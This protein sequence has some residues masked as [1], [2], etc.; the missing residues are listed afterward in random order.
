MFWYIL[1]IALLNIC[2]GFALAAHLGAR[3][4]AMLAM[5]G[6][7]QSPAPSAVEPAL[8]TTKA[9]VEPSAGEQAQGASLDSEFPSDLFGSLDSDPKVSTPA[10]DAPAPA[11]ESAAD[12][13]PGAAPEGEPSESPQPASR[14]E[15]TLEASLAEAAPSEQSK[16]DTEAL[17]AVESA[18]AALEGEVATYDVVLIETNEK[19]RAQVQSPE[20]AAIEACL[21]SLLGA[22]DQYI[23][24]RKQ[25]QGQL[26]E[27]QQAASTS[28]PDAEGWPAAVED[29]DRGIAETTEVAQSFDSEGDLSEQCR[30]M[31]ARTDHLLDANHRVRGALEEYRIEVARQSGLLDDPELARQTDPLTGLHTRVALEAWLHQFWVQQTQRARRLCM[32]TIDVDGLGEVNANYGRRTGDQLLRAVTRLLQADQQSHLIARI[33]GQR[34]VLVFPDVESHAAI[35]SIE[36]IRQTLELARFRHLQGD[37]RIT[38]S[39]AVAEATAEDTSNSLLT[40]LDVTLQEAKR[41]GRNRTFAYEGRYPTPVVPPN[42]T[43]EEKVVT[44]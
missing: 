4:R 3:Y 13:P 16:P 18:T 11:D 26:V 25:A 5:I 29:Q 21:A 38:I 27:A 33:G 8:V 10:G 20:A 22:T 1:V 42:F 37:I 35:S 39:G 43:L 2:L 19:L 41:Y 6:A 36:R 32:G 40:R 12:Q 31:V 9:P 28:Q 24:R 17:A 15:E 23:R 34:F 44:L 7:D 14:A 30:Q